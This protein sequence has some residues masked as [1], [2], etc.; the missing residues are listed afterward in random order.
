MRTNDTTPDTPS[1]PPADP[2]P[3]WER[4]AATWLA[5]E[6]DAGQPVTPE[7]LARETSVTPAYTRDLLQVLRAQRAR[8]PA[9]A[10][11]R[12]RLVG[13]RLTTLYVTRE[14]HGG[15]RLDPAAL[16]AELGTTTT[17]ARQW[18]HG[19]R[20]QQT[21]EQGMGALLEPAS[22]GRPSAEQLAGLAAHF[23]DGGHQR[24]A[25]TGRPADPEALEVEVERRYW[26]REARAGQRL[27]PVALAREL[28]T[29]PHLVAAQ[30]RELRAGPATARERI[31]QLWHAQQQDPGAR[32]LSSSR[33]AHR[34]GVT[35]SYVRHVTWRLRT[36]E[37]IAP[38]ADR[39]AATRE[40]L[41]TPPPPLATR[42]DP[43]RDWR[44]DAA[45]RDA[46]PE[47]FF[48]D[49]GQ[50]PQVAAAKE[51]CAGCAV[52]QP[53]LDTALHGP[54]RRDD[55]HGIFAGTTAHDR[56]RLRG[57]P[58]M[59]EGT[60]FLTDRAAA[61]EALALANRVS[62]DRAARELGVSKQ[63]LR[64]AFDHHGLPQPQ[65][66]QGGP[67]RSPAYH[68]R[69][70]AEQAWR[71]ATEVGI[72][73][74]RKEL[75]ISDRA[76]R[77]AWAH[78]GLGL[79]PR[80]TSRPPTAAGGRL[81]PTFVALNPEVIPVRP[82]SEAE[83]FAR[84]RRA[85]QLA[86]LG[87]DV[88]VELNTESRCRQQARVAAITRRAQ[89]A[90]TLARQREGR[91]ERRSAERADRDRRAHPPRAQEREVLPDGR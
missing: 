45:C 89:R 17:V 86:T 19:L 43:E 50:L 30:L 39:L 29:E 85:E 37:G 32:P 69:D 26:T 76:L 1:G 20:A 83:R 22:H 42:A 3:A 78:H 8:D 68:D 75:G 91:S 25:V 7:Q 48:P 61:E 53:C 15:E 79:P 28:G 10:E 2:R 13:D 41:S 18:L 58:A 56:T 31:E 49:Q 52:R 81:D 88:V 23:A 46:D 33:L 66:F 34:L 12:A 65:V 73:Q 36:R 51:V 72:N 54:L 84:V 47:L 64:H 59:A 21:S 4:I 5:R 24:A 16:A 71:R 82:G 77:N 57:R 44:L 90:Q 62:L 67:Q 87:A 63:A 11:L 80:P 74:T 38:L 35:D 40:R 60:R 9:L 27:N 14:V 6:V 55:Q 70:T